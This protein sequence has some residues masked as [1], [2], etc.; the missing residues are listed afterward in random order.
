MAFGMLPNCLFL[1]V[2][3]CHFHCCSFCL[4]SVPPLLFGRHATSECLSG[5]SFVTFAL[6]GYFAGMLLG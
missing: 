2:M 4:V 5:S 3:G 6:L 1:D